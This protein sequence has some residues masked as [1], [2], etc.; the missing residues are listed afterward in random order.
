MNINEISSVLESFDDIYNYNK[1][2]A[3]LRLE[4]LSL[5]YKNFDIF[6]LRQYLYGIRILFIII[7]RPYFF[8]TKSYINNS[9]DLINI[10]IRLPKKCLY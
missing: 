6:L 4:F 10:I 9:R 5:K 1:D 7:K 3:Q 8:Y 2:F